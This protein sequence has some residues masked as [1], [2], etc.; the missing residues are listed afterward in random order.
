MV[1]LGGGHKAVDIGTSGFSSCAILETAQVKCWGHAF[2]GEMG[3]GTR[4]N[5]FPGINSGYPLPAPLPPIDLP[6]SLPVIRL[7][8]GW[9]RLCAVVPASI[10]ASNDT[11]L[12][13]CWG[14]NLQGELGI[15]RST[16]MGDD[17]NE[18]GIFLPYVGTPGPSGGSA[19][20]R[21]Y[22]LQGGGGTHTC[23]LTRHYAFDYIST[24]R[25]WGSNGVG[26]LGV[27]DTTNRGDIFTAGHIPGFVELGSDLTLPLIFGNPQ[28]HSA[29]KLAV[30]ANHACVRL[31]N[32]TVKCWGYNAAG[33]LGL[34]DQRN[35]GTVPTDMGDALP[36]LNL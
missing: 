14:Q 28:P 9:Q 2:D 26:E 23:Q 12:I 32:A 6:T 16:N 25:C 4:V 34:G 11:N 5:Q 22:D 10:F 36:A 24:P 33:Q 13:K 21:S 1:D 29:I 18:M 7:T 8:G 19:L 17:P 3:N 27:G 20:Q 30:G 31:E 15:Y 35:R